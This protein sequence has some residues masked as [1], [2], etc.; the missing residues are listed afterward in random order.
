LDGVYILPAGGNSEPISISR[1]A[2]PQELLNFSPDTTTAL[3]E[4]DVNGRGVHIYLTQDSSD[5]RT[6]WWMDWESKTFWPVTITTNYEPT[7]ICSL[8]ATAIE[9]MG[10]ILGGRDG[11][12][13]RLS[14]LAET[15]DGTVYTTYVDLGPIPLAPDG[16]TGTLM[17]LDAVMGENGA[18]VTWEIFPGKT[19]EEV[20]GAS[21]TNFTGTWVAGIN[22][23]V[24]PGGRGQGYKIRI[25]GTSGRKWAMEQIVTRVRQSGKRRI[26]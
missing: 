2:L 19:F 20:A 17:E 22:A 5:T 8:Q 1:E 3:M 15:D 26:A 9:D 12:L 6:H 10:V 18:D 11:Y 7:A 14:D 23:T 24:R 21:S 4:Y 25:T 16:M 13:R